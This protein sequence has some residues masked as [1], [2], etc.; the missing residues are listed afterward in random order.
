MFKEKV[1][2]AAEIS[3]A[4]VLITYNSYS[5]LEKWIDCVTCA[6]EKANTKADIYVIDN[7]SSD[8]TEILLNDLCNNKTLKTNNIIITHF[9]NG[10]SRAL[11]WTVKEKKLYSL[12]SHIAL[13]NIDAKIEKE[14]LMKMINNII[15]HDDK[16]LFGCKILDTENKNIISSMG[17][18]VDPNTGKTYDVGWKA[19]A[20]NNEKYISAI[21]TPCFAA[22]VFPV[23][24]FTNV[25]FPDN[26]QWMYY[27]D[28]EFYIRCIR[29]GYN[30]VYDNNI[31]AYHPVPRNKN[32]KLI[33][34]AQEDGIKKLKKILIDI[35][36]NDKP[37]YEIM[38]KKWNL[39][40]NLKKDLTP[41]ST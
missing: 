38:E 8:K 20:S 40:V 15:K 11:N 37:L 33:V 7:G 13:V 14:W 19:D 12:Y 28:I 36:N 41:A 16:S 10:F 2:V 9:N 18:V 25:G 4:F 29:A 32:N 27:D 17:H 34:E 26:D 35:K 30:T 21:L 39:N 6:I 3:F 23:S 1:M 31:C 24:C 22:S 5:L